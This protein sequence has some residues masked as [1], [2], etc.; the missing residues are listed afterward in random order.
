FF[1]M[2]GWWNQH[3]TSHLPRI[4]TAAV[5]QNFDTGFFALG[6]LPTEDWAGLGFGVSMLLAISATASFL[7]RCR[8]K[9]NGFGV[10]GCSVI[11]G[12]LRYFLLF[13]PWIALLAYSAKSGMTTAA[14]LISPYYPL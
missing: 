5:D 12:K 6:E 10:S 1:P 9:K 2:A 14:R 7:N 4:V 11:P 3:I 8:Q 13:A